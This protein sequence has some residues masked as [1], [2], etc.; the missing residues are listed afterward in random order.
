MDELKGK[1][2]LSEYDVV[3]IGAGPAGTCAALRLL[4]LGYRVAIIEQFDFPR[5]QIGESLSPG[6]WNIFQYLEVEHL[7][8]RTRYIRNIPARIIWEQQAEKRMSA[9]ERG[10]GIIV[11]RGQMD[12]DLLALCRERGA[13][14]FQ[15]AKLKYSKFAENEWH[16]EIKVK[17]RKH[18]IQTFF[19]FD[20]RG[21]SGVPVKDR[22]QTSP[23]SVG[24]W[25]HLPACNFPK[26]TLIEA[27]E[28][29][30]LWG[31]PLPNEEFRVLAFVEP[32]SVKSVSVSKRLKSLFA[33][34]AF[35]NASTH[36]KLQNYFACPV[37]SFWNANSWK[38][39][40]IYLGESAFTIDPLS[41]TG[42]EKAMRFSLQSVIAFNTIMKKGNW[43]IAKK[44]YLENLLNA[45]ALHTRWTQEFYSSS[46]IDNSPFWAARRTYFYAPEWRNT[47][48]EKKLIK[49]MNRLNFTQSIP[50]SKDPSISKTLSHLN[51][52][53]IRISKELTYRKMP[54][55]VG[56]CLEMKLT[57]N[58]PGLSKPT[59]YIGNIEI[60][61]LLQDLETVFTIDLVIDKWT[62][63]FGL[64]KSV[65]LVISLWNLGVFEKLR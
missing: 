3:V 18:R 1:S 16:L 49:A 33:K 57:I 5:F 40:Y 4:R 19:V 29:G 41:S 44:F 62:A 54:C 15:P 65:R 2:D 24:I 56:D 7:L 13:T 9:L 31:S 21:K 61:P 52:I 12:M 11:D 14:V 38:E 46:Y 36:L 30:W 32:E 45:V 22:I 58:H 47:N 20:A 25:T 43:K 23:L 42:V 35:F 17:E 6:I 63:L 8:A 39:N 28:D 34:S 37:Q 64:K 26:A 59:A 48:N 27:L 60:A 50:L 10:S 55:V 51:E 53:P